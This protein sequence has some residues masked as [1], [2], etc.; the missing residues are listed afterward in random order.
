MTVGWRSPLGGPRYDGPIPGDAD[1]DPRVDEWREEEIEAEIEE[2]ERAR[3]TAGY[4][5]AGDD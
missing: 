3:A 4:E 1:K 2:L 5:G